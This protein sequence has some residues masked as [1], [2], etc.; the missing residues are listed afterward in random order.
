M[1]WR[2][3]DPISLELIVREVDWSGAYTA[4][5]GEEPISVTA[6]LEGADTRFTFSATAAESAIWAIGNHPFWCRDAAGLTR[7]NGGVEVTR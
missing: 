4:A 1:Q 3:G 2:H 6:V 5:V 7:F